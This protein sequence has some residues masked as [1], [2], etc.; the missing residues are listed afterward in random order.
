[1]KAMRVKTLLSL[2]VGFA[3]FTCQPVFGQD[4]VDFDR[5][6][7]ERGRTDFKSSCGFCHG[8]DATGNRAPDLIRSSTTNHDVNGNLLDPVIRNGRPDR[9]MPAFTNLKD[10]DL[11][12]IVVFLHSQAYA[13]LHSAHVPGDYPV[14]KLLTGNADRGKTYFDGAG[15]C[16][17][18]H[19]VT[20]DLAGI[21]T[22]L[23]PIDLQ[24]RLVYPEA[25]GKQTATVTTADGQS[26]QGKVK[27]LDEFNVAIIDAS[28]WYHSWPRSHVKVEVHDPLAAHRE[29]TEKY[30]DGDIHDLFAYLETLK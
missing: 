2:L 10:K 22:K 29:L 13:A 26:F 8:D 17:Q 30:T 16:T 3:G 25:R 21:A 18:C 6:A 28:G 14:A 27:D 12:D 23:K 20:G 15:G 5:A 4:K 24:Q 7:V 11:A 19:S 9:G 1:M